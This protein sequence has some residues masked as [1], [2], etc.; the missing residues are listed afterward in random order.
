MTPEEIPEEL[1][2]ILDQRAGKEH[3]RQGP[4]MAALAEILTQHQK[5]LETPKPQENNHGKPCRHTVGWH[6][7]KRP[8][9]H[10]GDHR[11]WDNWEWTG[12][13]GSWPPDASTGASGGNY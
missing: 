10:E 6:V 7:C 4:V 3:S 2:R 9:A 12:E 8:S 13:A 5:M 1:K 11:D